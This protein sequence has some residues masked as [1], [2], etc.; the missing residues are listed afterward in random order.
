[1]TRPSDLFSG[2]F[3]SAASNAE[4]YEK[5]VMELI[6]GVFRG[7]WASVFAYGQTGSGKL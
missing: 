5:A 1:M 3:C 7:K 4:I 2:S 6:P